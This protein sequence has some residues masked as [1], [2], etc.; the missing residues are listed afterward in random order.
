MKDALHRSRRVPVALLALL[1]SVALT[2]SATARQIEQWSYER[3]FKEADLVVIATATTIKATDDRLADERWRER[4]VGQDTTFTVHT[5]LKGEALDRLTVLHFKLKEEH[6]RQA[7][8][9]DG[10]LLVGFRTKGPTIVGGGSEKYTAQLG[11][12]QYLLFLKKSD[13]GRFEPLSG[14]IDPRLSVKEI[15]SPL[16][17]VIDEK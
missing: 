14:Q 1:A 6:G 8:A 13:G 11:T 4:L 5:V 7:A 15:Y 17:G 16:P 2:G 12:P 10:P 3:L 9:K